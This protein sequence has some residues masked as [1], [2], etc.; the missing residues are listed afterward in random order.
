MSSPFGELACC[1]SFAM[2][3]VVEEE[4]SCSS[5]KSSFFRSHSHLLDLLPNLLSRCC[6]FPRQ[7]QQVHLNQKIGCISLY[8][9]GNPLLVI[10]F[11]WGGSWWYPYLSLL[12]VRR[13]WQITL[14]AS[15]IANLS[16]PWDLP[17]EHLLEAERGLNIEETI[18]CTMGGIVQNCWCN[19]LPTSRCHTNP[20]WQ[21]VYQLCSRE[22]TDL[23]SIASLPKFTCGQ[24]YYYPS[25]NREKDG[26]KLTHEVVHNLTRTTGLFIPLLF[27]LLPM[28]F[29]PFPPALR[30]HLS[31]VPFYEKLR[32]SSFSEEVVKQKPL[33]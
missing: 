10:L 33:W 27:S 16:W 28:S 25:F 13:D 8:T 17:A 29:L 14:K 21:F 23:A 12:V 32:A 15:R 26:V 5:K 22:Y 19:G 18:Q 1:L 6:Y 31:V 7:I 20:I 2:L 11:S 30:N 9:L 4:A 24:L 3:K